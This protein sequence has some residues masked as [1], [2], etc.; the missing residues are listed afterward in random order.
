MR[1]WTS[2]ALLPVIALLSTTA[3]AA[4]EAIP[5]SEPLHIYGGSAVEP[6]GWPTTVYVDGCTGTLVDPQVVVFAAHCMFFA[7][8]AQ[9]STIRFGEVGEMPEREVP[10]VGCAM[11]P[12][13]MPDEASF[14]SDVAFCVLEEPVTDVPIV[15]ILMG[16]ETEVLQPG[17]EITLVGFGA[18]E[19]G[20]LGVKHEVV[21][22]IN[23]SRNDGEVNVGGNGLSSCN[24]DSG[25]PAYVQLEDGSWRAF[26]ITSRGV[27]GNCSDP[28]VYG[29]IHTHVEWIEETSGL[30]ITPCHDADGV[31]NP[32]ARCTE[33]PL[34]PGLGESTWAEGCALDL[35]SPPA[36]SCGDPFDDGSGTTGTGGG[37]ETGADA[38][39][40]TAGEGSSSSSGDGEAG[41]AAAS[42]TTTEPPADT[43][44]T[45][46]D[47]DDAESSGCGCT[48][49]PT[50]PLGFL[51]LLGCVPLVRRRR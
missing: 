48:T 44:D 43:D 15:P 50:S 22:T 10:T 38:S 3:L 45:F 7:G 27:S 14:G 24:G 12:G 35:L 42:S 40:G 25:G 47:S 20:M 6:C 36:A 18:T 21:T 41:T 19:S 30:D 26:G 34:T 16:C 13:W 4:S 17:Q 28:S 2:T 5:G 1:R 39:G 11:F 51:F 46:L 9:P 33:F 37:S 23:G 29:L 31:W 32:D 8:G 49:E